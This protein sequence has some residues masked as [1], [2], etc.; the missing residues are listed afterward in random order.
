METDAAKTGRQDGRVMKLRGLAVVV[1]WTRG[2]RMRMAYPG[3]AEM[4]VFGMRES[5]DVIRQQRS[6]SDGAP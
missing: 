3:L 2:C 5:S 6:T 4:A 1:I